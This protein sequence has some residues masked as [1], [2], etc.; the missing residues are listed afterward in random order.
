[1]ATNTRNTGSLQKL[2]EQGMDSLLELQEGVQAC[3][4]LDFG[5]VILTVEF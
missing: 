1:M 2:E 3:Q 4:H 5:L